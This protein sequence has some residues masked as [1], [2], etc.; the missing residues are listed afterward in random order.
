VQVNWDCVFFSAL[1][2]L[3]IYAIADKRLN[4]ALK[5]SLF[6]CLKDCFGKAS[7]ARS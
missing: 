3:R 5:F 4:A 7:A 2:Y 6:N 1:N